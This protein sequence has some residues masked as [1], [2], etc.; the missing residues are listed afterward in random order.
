MVSRLVADVWETTTKALDP[1][2]P[3]IVL[4]PMLVGSKGERSRIVTPIFLCMREGTS[5]RQI[6]GG[7]SDF[8]TGTEA[9]GTGRGHNKRDFIEGRT[10]TI[11][12]SARHVLKRE[13]GARKERNL[14]TR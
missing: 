13:K 7:P 11:C 8:H 3:R 1:G 12:Y 5:T 10:A 2:R 6:A 14:M 9:D 4:P